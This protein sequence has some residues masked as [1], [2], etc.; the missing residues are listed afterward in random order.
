M[1]EECKGELG[2]LSEEL[3]SYEDLAPYDDPEL[4]V[5]WKAECVKPLECV[6]CREEDPSQCS[7]SVS[8]G[9]SWYCSYPPVVHVAKK[10]CVHY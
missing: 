6:E 4:E 7:H 8:N 2:E 5:D 10:F 3:F 9:G 1:Q